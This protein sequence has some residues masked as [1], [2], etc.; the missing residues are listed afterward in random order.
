MQNHKAAVQRKT[1]IHV[2]IDSAK[3]NATN[4]ICKILLP[5]I[6]GIKRKR[7]IQCD[8]S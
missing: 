6:E 7:E 8:G 5:S 3:R 4:K 1:G 2:D